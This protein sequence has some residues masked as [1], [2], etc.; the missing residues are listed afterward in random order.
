MYMINF[1]GRFHAKIGRNV[2]KLPI[3]TDSLHGISSN[4]VL[5]VVNFA[6][7]KYMSI[8]KH[9]HIAT[10]INVL[11]LLMQDGTQSD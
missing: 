9:S 4:N 6:M 8:V 3:G 10:F 1:N 5:R 11:G 7:P 2:F